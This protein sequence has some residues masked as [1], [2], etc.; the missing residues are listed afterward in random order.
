MMSQ[1]FTNVN[2]LNVANLFR[3]QLC[4]SVLRH[5]VFSSMHA[6]LME[7]KTSGTNFATA[8]T[9]QKADFIIKVIE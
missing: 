7:T 8:Q 9:V 4:K 6:K 1:K 2:V 5:A 3:R